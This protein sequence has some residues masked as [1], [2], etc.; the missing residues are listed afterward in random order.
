M[1]RV[2][3]LRF[4]GSKGEYVTDNEQET[5]YILSA[6]TMRSSFFDLL[7]MYKGKNIVR[8]L[9]RGYDSGT[10]VGLCSAGAQGLA[11]QGQNYQA[12]IKYYFPYARI[13]DTRTGALH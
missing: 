2:I 13:L 1:G 4:V 10:G 3:I 7:P 5:I 9:V 11:R 6:G 12:I 8:V